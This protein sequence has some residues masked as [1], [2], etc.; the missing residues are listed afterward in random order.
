MSFTVKLWSFNKKVNSTAIPTTTASEYSCIVKN[1]TKI[2]R[3]IIE[4]NLGFTSDPSTYNYA[5]I[6]AFDR[7]YFIDE[8]SFDNGLWTASMHTDVLAT[9]KSQIGNSTL[10]VLRAA[11]ASDGRVVDNLYPCKTGADFVHEAVTSPFLAVGTYIVGVVAKN[12]DYGSIIYYAMTAAEVRTLCTYLIT[13]AVSVANNFNLSDASMALQRSI[14]DPIQYIKSC[15]FIPYSRSDLVTTTVSTFNIFNWDVPGLTGYVLN[16]NRNRKTFSVSITK[17][18]DTNY[19]GNYVNAAP[20]TLLSLSFP[21]F[22]VIEI[23]TS[24]TCNASTLDLTLDVDLLTGRG[25]LTIQANGVVLNKLEAQVGVPIQLA[26]VKSDYVGAITSIAGGVSS[27][28]SGFASGGPAGIAGGIS[29]ALS[30]IGNAVNALAPR[31]Q[32]IGSGGGFAQLSGVFQLDHQFFRPVADDNTHYGRPLCQNRQIN[33]LSGY[34]LIQEG[35]IGTVGF[36][37]ENQEIKS[38]LESGFY[39]E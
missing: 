23:D 4:L 3:P 6:S 2:N 20:Y 16:L 24:V 31:A 12:G 27:A 18:P 29:G 33:S 26:Q 17:H 38:I 14:V 22:G 8:W 37:E 21:P 30:G 13:D 10:Y 39:Y 7:Y 15:I 9:F 1:G 5:Q 34:M 36:V 28:I 35:D 25:M 11:G 32:T 19:R